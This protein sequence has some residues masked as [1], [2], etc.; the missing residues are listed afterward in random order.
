[1]F[2]MFC[3]AFLYM[4]FSRSSRVRGKWCEPGFCKRDIR[5]GKQKAVKST[6]NNDR[7]DGLTPCRMARMEISG[8]GQRVCMVGW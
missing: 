1:M 8:G 7:E 2:G 5:D 4:L 3:F 6:M